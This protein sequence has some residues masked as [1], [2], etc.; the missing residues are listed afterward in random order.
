MNNDPNVSNGQVPSVS[1]QP[2]PVT[3]V[4]PVT[5]VTPVTPVAPV[6][7]AAPTIPTAPVTP[8]AP[9]VPSAVQAAPT[10]VA[11]T[12]NT[13]QPTE[14][15]VKL[16]DDKVSLKAVSQTDMEQKTEA[17]SE[18]VEDNT[19]KPEENNKG[20]GTLQNIFLFL[21]FGGLLAFI[22]YIDDITVYLETRKANK[23]QVIE[24]IT[25]GTLACESERSSDD[26]D[27]NYI[28]RF[29]FR[30]NK[31]KRLNYSMEVRGDVN[32]DEEKLT[33]LNKECLL[34]KEYASKLNG[35]DIT[36]SLENGLLK[37]KQ[38][39]TYDS[40]NREEAMSA[41]IEAGGVYPEYRKDQNIDEIEREMNAA[42]Y[43]CKRIK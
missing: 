27:Y 1:G 23:N 30:D 8:A 37:E 15:R 20:G 22:I 17:T 35:I 11:P 24:K 25:T 2:T 13:T 18:K 28:A 40:V 3:P 10:V 39:F 21:L 34:V 12:S 7:P 9:A 5:P 16:V 38:V 33:E 26:M 14:Q 6:T 29:E 36:C 41:F 4:V 31:L 43:S 19:D 32:L 42:A